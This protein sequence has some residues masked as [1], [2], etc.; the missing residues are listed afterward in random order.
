M[1]KHKQRYK[2]LKG[3]GHA[4]LAKRE[5]SY[6]IKLSTRLILEE[7]CFERNK[8][9]LMHAIN[10]SLELK[11]KELFLQLTATYNDTI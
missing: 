10:Q 6:E 9:L 1:K 11:D 4:R 7:L 5:I 2:F 8:K 3:S